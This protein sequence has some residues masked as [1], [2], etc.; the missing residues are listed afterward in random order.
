MKLL[1]QCFIHTVSSTSHSLQSLHTHRGTPFSWKARLA[2]FTGLTLKRQSNVLQ[3]YHS[4]NNGTSLGS[5]ALP[6]LA[7][8]TMETRDPEVG[9]TEVTVPR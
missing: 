8:L 3:G 7:C 6:N 9:G 4:D 2:S 5:Q 1:T